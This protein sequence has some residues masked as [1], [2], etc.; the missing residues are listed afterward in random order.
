MRKE[1]RLIVYV[2]KDIMEKPRSLFD[3]VY[4]HFV[5][6]NIKK[7]KVMDNRERKRFMALYM[8]APSA[9]AKLKV[10]NHWV[11]VRNIKTFP[12]QK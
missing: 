2:D 5:K 11:T 1:T 8:K 7:P 6:T 9:E 12:M 4:T 3:A 10:I